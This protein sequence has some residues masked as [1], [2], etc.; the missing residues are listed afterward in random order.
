[1]IKIVIA[2][3][4]PIFRQGMKQA[5][6][7]IPNTTVVAEAS[8]GLEA[9]QYILA[10]RPDMVILDLEMPML[11]GM[12]VCAKVK[13][14]FN[15]LKIIIMTMH[16]EKHYYDDAMK[17]GVSGYLLKDNAIEDLI[18]CIKS[19]QAN[20]NYISPNLHNFLIDSEHK[21]DMELI[22]KL[23]TPTEKVV[24]KLI[25]EGKKTSEI[26]NLLFC[27]PNTVE[28]HRSNMIKKLKLDGEK[29]SLLKFA[30]GIKQWI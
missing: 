18:T 4:H 15:Q 20:Q 24:L 29:N 14:E 28:N 13:S 25:S 16:K 19:V 21:S 7:L 5:I 2:D 1:M 6:D 12:D 8:N 11:S 23:L 3:D 9:Y 26:A 10:E 17:A 27:S 30:L 22:S